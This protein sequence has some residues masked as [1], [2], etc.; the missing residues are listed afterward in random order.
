MADAAPANDS[1]GGS[2]TLN[3]FA[4]RTSHSDQSILL[5]KITTT[6]SWLLLVISAIYTTFAAPSGP[7]SHK[8]WH[9]NPQTP[10]AQSSIFTS[11]YVL[12][13][14]ILQ[15]G[16]AYA[17]YMSDETYVTAAANL[18]SHF[19]ANNL[20]LFGFVHLFTRSHFWLAL[21]LL[22]LNFGNLSLAY[23]R[24]SAAP[25][26]IHV[27]TVSGPLAWNFV[28]LYWVGA[29]AVHSNHFAARIVANVF[30][31]GWLGYGMFFLVAYKDYT[32]G[33]AL[34]VLAFSTGVGQFLT[35]PHLLQLQWIFAFSIGGLLFVLSLAVGMPGLLGRDPFPR[36]Q[37]VSEDQ[38]RAP[39]LADD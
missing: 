24:H 28:A 33:F 19:I 32:M 9:N 16:Y 12:I 13:I 18:G 25:R 8:L 34:S 29:I 36:G 38:E 14:F 35:R 37:I 30:I 10:F 7:H 17:L 5:Y 20:L 27:G 11:I 3:P 15:G 2:S 26:T 6:I 39:L 1:N 4:K 21:F 23:F 31:W 22:V